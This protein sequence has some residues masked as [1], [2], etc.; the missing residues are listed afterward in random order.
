MLRRYE[1]MHWPNGFDQQD[2]TDLSGFSD[3]E[4]RLLLL[5]LSQGGRPDNPKM[6]YGMNGTMQSRFPDSVG[7]INALKARGYFREE[8]IAEVIDSATIASL[9]QLAIT[10]GIPFK[11][12]FRNNDYLA[13][14][15]P[16]ITHPDV[17]KY[18]NESR[19]LAFSEKGFFYAKS[20]YEDL[21]KVEIQV[22]THM[23]ERHT[24]QAIKIWNEY[25]KKQGGVALLG[26]YVHSLRTV[27][28]GQ[29][30]DSA[31]GALQ[32]C[33]ELYGTVPMFFPAFEVTS[34]ASYATLL[35]IHKAQLANYMQCD[36][37]N[38][39]FEC[40]YDSGT[41]AICADL[42]GRM[43]KLKDAKPSFNYPPMHQSCRCFTSPVLESKQ[44]SKDAMPKR[45]RNPLTNKTYIVYAKTYAK[46]VDELN[47]EELLALK[48][49]RSKNIGS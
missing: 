37:S 26:S 41:C 45:A 48:E 43:F 32:A 23:L 36:F 16:H 42:D 33:I 13:L 21:R 17:I 10:L 38:Y 30:A 12:K 2:Y 15:L 27:E 1:G 4:Y 6:V 18:A 20:L 5:M 25:V 44:K 49:K 19:T 29:Y 9:K 31:Q 46:W 11:S 40:V 7:A 3:E 8:S 47:K 39:V 24:E 14:I 22:Y 35:A 34:D 28:Y